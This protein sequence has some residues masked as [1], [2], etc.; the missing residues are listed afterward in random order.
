LLL[1]NVLTT[2]PVTVLNSQVSSV[3][4]ITALT[5]T[6][7]DDQILV[8]SNRGSMNIWDLGTLKSI[9]LLIYLVSY[10]L[11]GHTV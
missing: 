9:Y 4:S 3:S 6:Q 8:G 11:K 7:S 1:Y 2:K 5:F 10:C